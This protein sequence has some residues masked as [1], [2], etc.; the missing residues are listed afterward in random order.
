MF[1]ENYE[2]FWENSLFLLEVNTHCK[3]GEEDSYITWSV[4]MDCS[5]VTLQKTTRNTCRW[6]K[7][8]FMN[9]TAMWRTSA[10]V[11]VQTLNQ[12]NRKGHGDW[13]YKCTM[14]GSY[15]TIEF[16]P[17]ASATNR[18]GSQTTTLSAISLKWS[19]LVNDWQL[20]YF[21][22]VSQTQD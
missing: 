19:S 15:I 4:D 9:S 6:S 17:T 11:L 13:M 20:P 18:S 16:W 7:G 12:K 22:P 14:T 10:A 3:K 1:L 21:C 2:I 8:P 5:L